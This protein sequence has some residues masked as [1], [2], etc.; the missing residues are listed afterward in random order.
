MAK[1]K[2]VLTLPSTVDAEKFMNA[3]ITQVQGRYHYDYYF[4]GLAAPKI[5]YR[6]T[7][8]WLKGNTHY[9][10]YDINADELEPA[11]ISVIADFMEFGN[12]TYDFRINGK[13]IGRDWWRPSDEE[14]FE[15]NGY[16]ATAASYA[17]EDYANKVWACETKIGAEQM[18][19]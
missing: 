1:L 13:S 19:A 6:S 5:D 4:N 11:V 18:T 9:S 2:M 14:L 17:A 16:D 15:V 12:Y 7:C 8:G 3:V 10:V